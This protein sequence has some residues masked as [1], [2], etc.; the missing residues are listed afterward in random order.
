MSPATKKHQQLIL[1]EPD[2]AQ[3]LEE[4][5]A[6]LQRPKQVLLRDAVDDL[7]AKHGKK[8]TPWYADIVIALKL[9]KMVATRYQGLTNEKNW[10]LKCEEL[11]KSANTILA[12]LGKLRET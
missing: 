2:Q 10:I 9:A 1:L 8:S 5:A 11:R 3:L 12:S 4:L 6:E 7:L